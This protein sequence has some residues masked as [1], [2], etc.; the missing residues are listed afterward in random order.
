MNQLEAD[1]C[2]QLKGTFISNDEGFMK[3]KQYESSKINAISA[4]SDKLKNFVSMS[5]KLMQINLKDSIVE[6]GTSFSSS[7]NDESN[8]V[9]SD[10]LNGT[11]QVQPYVIKSARSKEG[12]LSGVVIYETIICQIEQDAAPTR[13][14]DNSFYYN[15]I[16][17]N[18]YEDDE[19]E[20]TT[21]YDD[22][23][24]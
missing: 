11:Q 18:L 5:S 13:N 23:D 20:Q 9:N 19:K 2:D 12:R 6:A 1:D 22:E 8:C 21:T 14:Q 4:S 17:T 24:Q 10:H 3:K 7:S 16:S 15:D